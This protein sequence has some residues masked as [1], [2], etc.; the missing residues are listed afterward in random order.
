MKFP[1]LILGAYNWLRDNIHEPQQEAR[2]GVTS[3]PPT[4]EAQN[5]NEVTEA[6]PYRTIYSTEELNL[7]QLSQWGFRGGGTSC[8]PSTENRN[9]IEVAETRV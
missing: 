8:P 5:V 4:V 9:V 2:V 1:E 6:I 7:R 3:S